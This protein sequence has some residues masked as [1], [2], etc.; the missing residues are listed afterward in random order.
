MNRLTPNEVE[1]LDR[2]SRGQTIPEIA[3]AWGRTPSLVYRTF[4][5]AR[6]T[7][8]ARTDLEAMARWARNGHGP[9]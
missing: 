3:T 1:L 6:L 2:L 5:S 8:D 4:R 7:L 9:H